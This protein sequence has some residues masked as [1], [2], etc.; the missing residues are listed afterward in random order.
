M[1]IHDLHGQR[2]LFHD[3]MKIPSKRWAVHLFWN[4]FNHMVLNTRA[5]SLDANF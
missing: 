5:P 4:M 3:T 2:Q 1:N